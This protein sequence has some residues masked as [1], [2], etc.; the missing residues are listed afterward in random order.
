MSIKILPTPIVNNFPPF[1]PSKDYNVNFVYI[2]EQHNRIRA[3]IIENLS[4]NIVYDNTI[5][6]GNTS[7]PIPRYA[8]QPG[9]QYTIQIQVLYVSDSDTIEKQSELSDSFLF[10][11]FSEPEFSFKE[12]SNNVEYN[13]SDILLTLNYFQAE[14][15]PIRNFQFQ[16]YDINNTLINSSDVFYHDNEMAYAFYKM[17][18]NSYYSFRAI[19]ETAHGMKLDTGYI[20][21]HV[22]YET[23]PANDV[24]FQLENNYCNGYIVV[25]VNI[26]DIRYH[27]NSLDYNF[28]DGKLILEKD[29][30]VTYFY[31]DLLKDEFSLFIEAIKLPYGTFFSTQNNELTLSLINVCGTVYCK[32]ALKDTEYNLFVPIEE[33]ALDDNNMIYV[34]GKTMLITLKR[35]NEIYYLD[36]VY[37]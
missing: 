5:V 19:G 6:R 9:K 27:V 24:S 2:G 28:E 14:N 7:Y 34:P 36:I 26:K 37:N 32:L 3:L 12:I 10:Y 13:N 4:S 20:H 22:N 23:I 35:K 29:N 25:T 33:H 11:C 18:N 16:Q 31:E 1:D 8:L 30:F 15:E 21:V 17:N